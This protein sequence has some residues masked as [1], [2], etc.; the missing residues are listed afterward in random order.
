[1]TDIPYLI[2]P[3]IPDFLKL[4]IFFARF[5]FGVYPAETHTGKCSRT[6]RL[7]QYC[8][9]REGIRGFTGLQFPR[10]RGENAARKIITTTGRVT[11]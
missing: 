1:M 10:A 4:Y 3:F 8:F 7:A 6:D 5:F 2:N 11:P 9:Q